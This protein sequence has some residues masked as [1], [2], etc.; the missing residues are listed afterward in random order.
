MGLLFTKIWSFFGNEGKIKVSLTC[1][2]FSLTNRANLKFYF[3]KLSATRCNTSEC[4]LKSVTHS[5]AETVR[6]LIILTFLLCVLNDTRYN[7]VKCVIVSLC[8]SP[9]E[10]FPG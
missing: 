7:F 1:C 6:R 9:M 4:I 3:M 10:C 8:V 2:K 5:S